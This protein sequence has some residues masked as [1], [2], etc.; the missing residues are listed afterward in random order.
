VV[1]SEITTKIF[2]H[3]LH[4][5]SSFVE[6]LTQDSRQELPRVTTSIMIT[7][8]SA[9]QNSRHLQV[10]IFLIDF[11]LNANAFNMRTEFLEGFVSIFTILLLKKYAYQKI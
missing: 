11:V 6:E 5:R 1:E 3:L 9:I 2:L 7:R 8:V 4:L 10:V